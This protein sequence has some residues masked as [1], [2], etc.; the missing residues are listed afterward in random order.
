MATSLAKSRASGSVA[1]VLCLIV[2]LACLAG[3]IVDFFILVFPPE[4][5]S[6]DWRVGV[7]QQLADRSII[8]LFGMALVF[9]GSM[10]SRSWKRLIPLICLGLGVIYILSCLVILRDSNKL[11]TQMLNR[12][13]SQ[14][15]QLQAQID[16]ARSNPQLAPDLT[17]ANIQEA[18]DLLASQAN[19]L[20][21]N[22]KRSILKAG[23]SSVGNLIVIGLSF[24][25]LG[26]F[27]S[28]ASRY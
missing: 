17:S 14:A 11:H 12:I 24:L 13:D 15:S 28:K 18:S 9:Y 1:S 25:S 16:E 6:V 23:V 8:L 7:V 4:L 5:R 22:S 20:K 10:A 21:E 3:F 26:L 19:Q 2:G 27:G